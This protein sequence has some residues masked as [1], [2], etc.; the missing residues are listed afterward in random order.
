MELP[1]WK[2]HHTV[3]VSI[4]KSKLHLK[5]SWT[6]NSLMV[7]AIVH[8]VYWP[9]CLS[10]PVGLEFLPYKSR[11]WSTMNED[12]HR[13]APKIKEVNMIHALHSKSYANFVW[14]TEPNLALLHCFAESCI[15]IQNRHKNTKFDS[16]YNTSLSFYFWYS[17]LLYTDFIVLPLT[18]THSQL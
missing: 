2:T 11:C 18:Q 9:S 6:L 14:I 15:S 7:K 12:T 10:R 8:S 17:N 4:H 5:P 3:S 13:Q 16:K 1:G